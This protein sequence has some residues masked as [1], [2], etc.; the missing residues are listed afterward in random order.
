MAEVLG[1]IFL[2][3]L[4]IVVLIPFLRCLEGGPG[5]TPEDKPSKYVAPEFKDRE[6]VGRTEVG[7]SL[8]F[9]AIKV[10]LMGPQRPS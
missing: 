8:L 5:P 3:L 10:V 1:L 7:N 9:A 4:G 2:V 6:E